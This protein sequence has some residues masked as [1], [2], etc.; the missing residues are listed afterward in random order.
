[1]NGYG[2]E[3]KPT[4]IP[5][6]EFDKQKEHVY[7]VSDYFNKPTPTVIDGIINYIKKLSDIKSK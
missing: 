5:H 2:L 4:H 1:M 7:N 6:T 3:N